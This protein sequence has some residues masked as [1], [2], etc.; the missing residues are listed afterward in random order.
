MIYDLKS[1]DLCMTQTCYEI[2]RKFLCES[3]VMFF[4][5]CAEYTNSVFFA[6][7]IVGVLP[8]KKKLLLK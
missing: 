8:R 4:S 5:Q 1:K 2:Y 3:I 7:T 6:S